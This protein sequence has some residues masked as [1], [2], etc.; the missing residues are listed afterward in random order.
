[1]QVAFYASGLYT[2]ETSLLQVKSTVDAN[3]IYMHVIVLCE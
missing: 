3:E 2:R 1:M